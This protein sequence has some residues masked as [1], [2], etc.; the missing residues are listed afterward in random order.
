MS[1][2]IDD[3]DWTSANSIDST[4]SQEK[5]PPWVSPLQGS[6]SIFLPTSV[7]HWG[8]LRS[9]MAEVLTYC[10]SRASGAAVILSEGKTL[11]QVSCKGASTNGIRQ[12]RTNTTFIRS[13]APYNQT[14]MKL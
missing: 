10:Q 2:C 4:V 14:S 12:S 7:P 5:N 1:L 11:S 9:V 6:Y 13:S 3:L 8:S